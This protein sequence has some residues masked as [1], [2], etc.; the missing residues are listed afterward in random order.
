MSL[1]PPPTS[2]AII[3]EVTEDGGFM[4]FPWAIF[5]NQLFEGDAGETWQPLFTG[6]TT[7]GVPKI[8]GRVYQISQ[9]L[10]LFVVTITPAGGENSSAVAGTTYINNFPLT[11]N[12]NGINFAVSGLLGTNAGMCEQSS[13]R[14]YVP[15]WTTVTVPLTVMGIVEAS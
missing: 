6:L 12:G 5:I 13:N 4:T 11:M 3:T 9:Y 15:G 2:Q 8:T 10:S 14:I 1:E 7:V